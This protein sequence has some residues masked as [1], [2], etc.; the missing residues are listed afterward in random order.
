MVPHRRRSS[1]QASL[2]GAACMS[3]IHGRMRSRK[4]GSAMV[5]VPSAAASSRYMSSTP[6]TN[7]RL[8]S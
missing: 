3:S 5:A 2:A 4:R 1:A 8:V 7:R 6:S